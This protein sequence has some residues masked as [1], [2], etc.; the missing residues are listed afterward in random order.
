MAHFKLRRI[1]QT[2]LW[3]LLGDGAG[4]GAP[5]SSE[6][7]Q[8]HHQDQQRGHRERGHEEADVKPAEAAEYWPMRGE[9]WSIRDQY[10]PIGGPYWP[11]RSQYW[12][13]RSLPVSLTCNAP[14]RTHIRR[15]LENWM[16]Q[17]L[18]ETYKYESTRSNYSIDAITRAWIKTEIKGYRY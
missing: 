17:I 7:H 1:L 13:M 8:V 14:H 10:W 3:W 11:I 16:L 9:L 2:P 5:E 4:G 18:H 6:H 15:C 12:P